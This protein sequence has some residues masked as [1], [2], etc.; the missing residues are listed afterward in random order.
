L[1]FTLVLSKEEARKKVWATLEDAGVSRFPGAWGRI[2]NFLGAEKAAVALTTLEE[3]RQ[4][5]T[6]KSNPDLAQRPVRELALREGKTVY[7]AV[8]RL[9]DEKC[10]IQLDQRV[11][12]NRCRL[13]ST[14]RGAFTMGK[15]VFPEDVKS[16]DLMVVGSVAV[17]KSGGRVGKGGGYSDLEYGIGRHLG[18]I[19]A[20]TP[21][22][23][24]VHP[25]QILQEEVE[26][27]PHDVPVDLVVTP[28]TIIRTESPHRKPC[29]IDWGLISSEQLQRIPVLQRIK[30]RT[31]NRHAE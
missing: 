1:V 26:M 7:M 5:E 20:E 25:L 30:G 18:V 13:A 6:I 11:V 16:I 10:F 27:K 9:K 15:K 8:P 31:L 24:T 21:V 2:P 29:G 3:W 28:G 22:V 23:T 12:G 19:K 4:A 17:D 14:I